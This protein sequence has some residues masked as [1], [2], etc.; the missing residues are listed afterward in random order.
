MSRKRIVVPL[1][2]AGSDPS[3][4]AGLQADMKVFLR[5]GLSGAALKTRLII[6]ARSSGVAQRGC[7][8]SSRTA[9]RISVLSTRP[10]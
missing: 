9:V 4:G 8:K 3:G 1:T 6:S 5:Y 2:I 10:S 7:E